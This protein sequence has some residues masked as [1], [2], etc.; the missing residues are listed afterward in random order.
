MKTI[1]FFSK[2]FV[3]QR[4]YVFTQSKYI[5][6]ATFFISIRVFFV[7]FFCYKKYIFI[8]LKKCAQGNYLTQRFSVAKS[9]LSFVSEIA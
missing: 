9:G 2:N 8:Q 3:I 5:C 7:F 6:I 4:K 1:F